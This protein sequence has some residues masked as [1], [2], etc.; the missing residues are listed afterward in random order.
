MELIAARVTLRVLQA[1]CAAQSL[2][3]GGP[4]RFPSPLRGGVRGGGEDANAQRRLSHPYPQPL[5]RKGEGAFM[6]S[7]G[8]HRDERVYWEAGAVPNTFLRNKVSA[9]RWASRFCFL[10]KPWPSSKAS[11]Y[12]TSWPFWRTLATI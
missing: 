9:S 6:R 1:N 3:L 8:H 11:M 12:Q 10:R 5:P 2:H 4:A 7:A